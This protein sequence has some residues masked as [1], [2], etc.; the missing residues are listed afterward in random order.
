MTRKYVVGG[1]WKC[2]GTVQSV[3]ELCAL[4]N[5]IEIPSDTLEV[6]VSPTSLHLALAKSLLHDKIA[7]CAQNV[8][9]TGTGA[10]TGEIAA[11]QLVDFGLEWTI[12]GHSERRACFGET[13]EIVA[14]KTKRALD[15]GLQVIFCIG[16]SLEERRANKTM[17]VLIRQTQALVDLV[18]EADWSRL[19]I[20]YEPVWAIGTG[21]VATPA[22]AQ[23]AHK[24]L[25]AW[26][27]DQVSS[28]V[29]G[30]VRIIYGGSVKGDNCKDLIA[31]D[32]VDG[33][34]VGGASLKPEFETIVKSAFK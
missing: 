12:T 25:R 13:D 20:A 9:L 6:V 17:D 5:K 27:A 10:Y 19:V 18:T 11:E 3:K 23:E 28:A 33:F 24:D 34:L 31:L 26:I 32:D 4:L 21:V 29:A 22:Q 1:N 2:N 30:N 7:L 16:E 14:K 8:S 15:L